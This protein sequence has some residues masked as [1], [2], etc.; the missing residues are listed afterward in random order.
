[1][2]EAKEKMVEVQRMGYS[3]DFN[4][5]NPINI[6]L[7]GIS[8]YANERRIVGDNLNCAVTYKTIIPVIEKVS[9]YPDKDGKDKTVVIKFADDTTERASTRHGDAFDLETGIS[10]CIA[11]KMYKTL[12][13]TYGKSSGF[14]KIVHKAVKIYKNG[15]KEEEARKK[16][17]AE[18]KLAEQRKEAKRK[19]RAEKRRQRKVNLFKDAFVAAFNETKKEG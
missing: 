9:V 10:L 8:Y 1:M 3:Y 19:K 7:T 14:S 12:A 13:G 2:C 17:E 18:E 6:N 4:G 5:K 15:I 16:R 11:K